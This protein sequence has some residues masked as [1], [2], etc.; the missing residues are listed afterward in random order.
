MTKHAAVQRVNARFDPAY[1]RKLALASRRLGLNVTDTLKAGLDRLAE[2]LAAK[3]A[4]RPYDAF[5]KAGF[6][7]CLGG[8]GDLSVSYKRLLGASVARK[9]GAR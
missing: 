7:G 9:Y 4:M 6:I 8:P 1:R 3:P 2:S 5:E